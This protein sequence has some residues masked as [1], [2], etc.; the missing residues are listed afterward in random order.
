MS[1][2]LLPSALNALHFGC[3]RLHDIM[4][5]AHSTGAFKRILIIITPSRNIHSASFAEAS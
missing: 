4:H 3:Y 2:M 1:L 5:H